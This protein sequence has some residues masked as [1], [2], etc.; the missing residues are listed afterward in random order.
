MSEELEHSGNPEK[1]LEYSQVYKEVMMLFEQIVSLIGDEEISLSELSEVLDTGYGEIRIGIIPKSVD[2]LPVCD[3]IRSRI[4]DVK[5]L[6]FIGVNDG[7]I[8]AVSAGG[9][10]I[11][12]MERTGLISQGMDLAP[13]RA[14]ESF[15]EQL[16]LYQILTKPTEELNLS[17]LSVTETGESKKPSY[18]IGELK[19][20][21][22]PFRFGRN[23][24]TCPYR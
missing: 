24:E 18:L 16:Y 11:S 19:K 14:G 12:D 7:N 9:G 23:G 4:G 17:F 22:R 5:A 21:F 8:P 15:T 6:F 20:M 1:A 2:V 3:L 13:D 10:L